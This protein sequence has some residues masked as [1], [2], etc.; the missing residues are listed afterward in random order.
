MS[1]VAIFVIGLVVTGLV[2]VYVA[3][4]GAAMRSDP[5]TDGEDG[6]DG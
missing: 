3:L 4:V 6:F 5:R 1:D 2:G